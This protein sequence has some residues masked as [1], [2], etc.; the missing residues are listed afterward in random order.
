V[1]PSASDARAIA[2]QTSGA[3]AIRKSVASARPKVADAA[4]AAAK[5]R[6]DSE[7][8]H[9]LELWHMLYSFP[10]NDWD[11]IEAV[12]GLDRWAIVSSSTRSRCALEASTE[13]A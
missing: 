11:A 10:P 4:R 7:R 1:S 6:A 3:T 13:I 12:T 5:Q 8:V 9:R 2:R